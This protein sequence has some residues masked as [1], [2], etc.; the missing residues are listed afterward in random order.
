[1]V[2]AESERTKCNGFA[3]GGGNGGGEIGSEGGSR[4]SAKALLKQKLQRRNKVGGVSAR[5]MYGM[6]VCGPKPLCPLPLKP[7]RSR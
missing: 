1:M 7:L 4:L 3:V 2:G 6:P 5:C